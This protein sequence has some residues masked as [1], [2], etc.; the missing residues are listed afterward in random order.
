MPKINTPG[1]GHVRHE[2]GN[3]RFW[4]YTTPGPLYMLSA[5]FVLI[6]NRSLSSKRCD[7]CFK[8][9]PGGRSFKEVWDDETIWISYDP[10]TDRT[11]YGCHTK[12]VFTKEIT[13]DLISISQ[14]AFAK[15]VEWVAGT[16]V[17]ELAHANGAPGKPSPLA[18]ATLLE[19]DFKAA[20][21]GA[22]GQRRIQL[23]TRMA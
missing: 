19:C 10:R 17:H 14:V 18:D 6:S 8:R 5:A 21:E 16:L 13:H 12:L 7:D 15:G 1:S 22:L 9:L 11:W 20:Y 3:F 2:V 4:A 23:P